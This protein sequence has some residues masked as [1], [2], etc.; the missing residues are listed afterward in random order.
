MFKLIHYHAKSFLSSNKFLMPLLTYIII[1]V[2]LLSSNIGSEK[3]I[4]IFS[5]V[6]AYFV[7]TWSGFVYADS[8]DHITEQIL[9]L[10]APSIIKYYISKVIFVVIWGLTFTVIG[11]VLPFVWRIIM[12]L[13]SGNMAAI[14]TLFKAT[15]IQN[16][17][18]SVVMH[19][20]IS[21]LGGVIGYLLHPRVFNNRKIGAIATFSLSVIGIIKGP[22][23]E[24]LQIP[25]VKILSF[26]LPPVYDIIQG[27][28]MQTEVLKFGEIL[29]PCILALVY[30][31]ILG[32]INVVV[33]NKR[34]F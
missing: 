13:F 5:M 34:G 33:I 27:C 10:K 30:S 8:E 18:C 4:Y 17:L 6:V 20:C 7:A 19:L 28:N 31:A 14:K 16:G 21:I 32:V 11:F 29:L 25:V 3:A 26:A 2:I 1:L 9:V 15:S 23:F 24:D 12:T 22:L